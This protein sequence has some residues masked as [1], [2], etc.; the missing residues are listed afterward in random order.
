MVKR[1]KQMR[2]QLTLVARACRI[3]LQSK[4]RVYVYTFIDDSVLY[5]SG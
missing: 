5:A 3:G 1:L 4:T 2:M